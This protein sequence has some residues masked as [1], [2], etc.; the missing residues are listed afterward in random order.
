[1]LEIERGPMETCIGATWITAVD[2]VE[3]LHAEQ[4]GP[5]HHGGYVSHL[6]LSNSVTDR[7]D[8]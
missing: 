4:L 6:L 5:L 2:E 7:R 3:T 1:M 8:H